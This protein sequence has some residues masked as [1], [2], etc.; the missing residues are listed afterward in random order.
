MTVT[1]ARIST[2]GRRDAT[3][4]TVLVIVCAGVVLASLDLFIVNIAFPAMQQ[5]FNGASV[6]K[7]AKIDARL[8]ANTKNVFAIRLSSF[9]F[10][11][12]T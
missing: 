12:C 3:P 6:A 7:M 8:T 1:A 10:S 9:N 11:S 4:T 5:D 2:V